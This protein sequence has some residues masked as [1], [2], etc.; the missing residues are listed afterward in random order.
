MRRFPHL[1]PKKVDAAVR[2]LIHQMAD[3][4]ASGER[5]EIRRF[6]SFFRQT[7]KP[8]LGRNPKTGQPVEIPASAIPRFRPGKP[9]GELVDAWRKRSADHVSEPDA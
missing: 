6:G 5:V 7:R 9:L 1:P 4:I 2:I 8:R 3:S